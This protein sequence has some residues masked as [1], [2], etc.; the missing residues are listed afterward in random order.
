[1]MMTMNDLEKAYAT[2]TKTQGKTSKAKSVSKVIV[3]YN[4][5]EKGHKKTECPKL[6]RYALCQEQGHCPNDCPQLGVAANKLK[7]N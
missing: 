1:M 3:C 7:G 6:L 2:F 5:H 4:C